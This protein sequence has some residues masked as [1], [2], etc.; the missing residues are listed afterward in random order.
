M[1]INAKIDYACKAILELA[2]HWPNII[3]LPIGT[4]AKNQKIPVKFLTQILLNL[5]QLGYVQST[6]GKEGGYLL[7]KAP[8]DIRLGEVIQKMGSF[9]YIDESKSHLKIQ[10]TVTQIWRELDNIIMQYLNQL[11]YEIICNRKRSN[12]KIAMFDI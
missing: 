9:S 10:D 6:R 3:P 12:E 4:I 8:R 7:A 2:L 1:K 11:N 5:K